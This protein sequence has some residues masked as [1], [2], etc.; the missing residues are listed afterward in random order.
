M[1]WKLNVFVSRIRR[2]ALLDAGC[3]AKKTVIAVK[4]QVT[5]ATMCSSHTI[6]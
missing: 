4:A 6:L 2:A 3:L 1:E 5:A